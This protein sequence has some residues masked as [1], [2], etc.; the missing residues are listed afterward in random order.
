MYSRS[1]DTPRRLAV[2]VAGFFRFDFTPFGLL[3]GPEEFLVTRA[4]S[5]LLKILLGAAKAADV[6]AVMAEPGSGKTVSLAWAMSEL[7]K[8]GIKVVKIDP[9]DSE[10]FTIAKLKREILH[11]LGLEKIPVNI[12]DSRFRKELAKA[13]RGKNLVLALDNA[14]GYDRRTLVALRRVNERPF[15]MRQ[16]MVGIVL[17]GYP[18]LDSKISGTGELNSRIVRY[19]MQNPSPDDVRPYVK[20]RLEAVGSSLEIFEDKAL[21]YLEEKQASDFEPLKFGDLNRSLSRALYE[22]ATIG[23]K[24]ISYELMVEADMRPED[25]YSLYERAGRPDRSK[26]SRQ[27][28]INRDELYREIQHGDTLQLEPRNRLRRHLRYLIQEREGK[29]AA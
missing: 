19:E 18:T 2:D 8:Q 23:E 17:S 1:V 25:T 27:L 10:R 4:H 24:K 22:A 21:D 29:E 13:S 14:H 12:T 11:G 7:E 26:L 15:A 5:N 3:T 9:T 20:K 16:R 6:V 28:G